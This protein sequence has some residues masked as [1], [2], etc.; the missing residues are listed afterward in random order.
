MNVLIASDHAGFE[1]KKELQKVLKA[2]NWIDHG[3]KKLDRVD[4]PDYAEKMAKAIQE[5]K[6][7]QGVL[8]CGTG[9]GMS[10]A[11]NKCPSIRAAHVTN[12]IEAHL[13]K[14]HNNA[15]II[16]VGARFLGTE[17]ALEIIRTFLKAK[18]AKTGRHQTRVDKITGFDQT[19]TVTKPAK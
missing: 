16:C 19:K 10:I 4:Y 17:Y 18:F 1:M 9:I 14:E 2:F 5:K 8:I 7:P 3:P 13:A 15:N 11:A 6:A 12:P